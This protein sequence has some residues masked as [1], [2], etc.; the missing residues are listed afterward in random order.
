MHQKIVIFRIPVCHESQSSVSNEWVQADQT[1][2]WLVHSELMQSGGWGFYADLSAAQV[3]FIVYACD[4]D[5][6]RLEFSNI[7]DLF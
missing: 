1:A 4:G 3:F 5:I 7:S 2:D 6:D